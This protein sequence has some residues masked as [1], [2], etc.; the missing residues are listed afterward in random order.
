MFIGATSGFNAFDTCKFTMASTGSGSK[1]QIGANAIPALY[2]KFYNTTFK[3]A[4]VGHVLNVNGVVD[5]I[6]TPGAVDGAGSIPTILMITSASGHAM[7]TFRGV[8]FSALGSGKTILSGTNG[9]V[10]FNFVDCK[11]GASVTKLASLP[12][13]SLVHFVITDSSGTNYVTEKDN[14]F[15]TQ[16]TETTIVRTGGA[17]ILSHSVS[18]KIVT[19][20][21]SNWALPFASVPMQVS[22]SSTAQNVTVTVYGIWGGGAVPN[23]D[24]IWIEAEYLGASGSPLGSYINS[25][26]ANI[27]AAGSAVAS[28]ASTWGGSTTPFKMSVTLSSPQPAQAGPINVRVFCAKLSTTFYIDPQPDLS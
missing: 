4:A 9:P 11:L 17:Q 3:F 8:D 6:N 5:W 25:S 20:S 23:N 24:D 15:G 14:I 21:S 26:K 7:G 2:T 12:S 13:T 19:T 28:D 22:N 16:T 1:I 10:Q 18:W 27:L